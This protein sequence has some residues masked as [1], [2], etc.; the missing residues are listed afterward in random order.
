[1]Y[2]NILHIKSL[3]VKHKLHR[4]VFHEVRKA[5]DLRVYGGIL[6]TNVDSILKARTLIVLLNLTSK[7]L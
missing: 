2:T 1:M 3:T 4:T 5:R 6:N 7:K